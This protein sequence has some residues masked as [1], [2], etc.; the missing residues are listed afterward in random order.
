[1][2]T[3]SSDEMTDIIV[4]STGDLISVSETFPIMSPAAILSLLVTCAS[5]TP[6]SE[7]DTTKSED[8]TIIV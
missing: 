1:M 2:G 4:P 7:E 6:C 5:K 8:L 3:V